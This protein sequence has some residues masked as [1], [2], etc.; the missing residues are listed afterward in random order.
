VAEDSASGFALHDHLRAT[1]AEASGDAGV[2][3]DGDRVEPGV[4]R[5]V[6]TG[7]PV[8]LL[9]VGTERGRR[10]NSGVVV[11]VAREDL[12]TF[13]SAANPD[14]NRP[15]S[16]LVTGALSDLGWQLRAFVGGLRARPLAAAAALAVFLA[17]Q[18]GEGVLPGPG[19]LP[20][21]FVILGALGLAYVGSRGPV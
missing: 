19:S 16:E 18:F 12:A 4:Y 3:A 14:G 20:A 2:D 8:A 5:V 1:G 9:R 21:V 17:G 10:V 7:D 13:E 6:G 11:R 15:P